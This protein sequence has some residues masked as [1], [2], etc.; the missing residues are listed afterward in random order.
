MSCGTCPSA[1]TSVL[2]R[3][4]QDELS[5]LL[6]VLKLS[7]FFNSAFGSTAGV[8]VQD[9]DGAVDS[10]PLPIPLN[11]VDLLQYALC[12]LTP[13]ALGIDDLGSL[14]SLDPTA[15]LAKIKSLSTGDIDNARQ[16]YELA[17]DNS[18]NAKLISQ[19][20][21]YQRETQRIAFTPQSFAEAIVIAATV[22]AVCGN[23]EF[24]EGPYRAFALAADGFTFTGGVPGV[25]DTNLAALIQKL[26]QGE[27]KFAALRGE[28]F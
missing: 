3:K 9:V 25:L 23:D 10:I 14:T 6:S 26:A 1:V 13:L 28:L 21:K 16:N 15:Q 11:F 4:V 19:A 20:R 5:K 8:A 27:A 18:P 17:L 12:P 2:R 7:D 22:Q 24:V